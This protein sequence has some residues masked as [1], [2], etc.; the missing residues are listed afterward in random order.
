V[1]P[2]LTPISLCSTFAA[3]ITAG[4][5]TAD[6]AAPFALNPLNAQAYIE[7]RSFLAA[8][9]CRQKK[10]DL[11]LDPDSSRERWEWAGGGGMGGTR[12]VTRAW[13]ARNVC[14]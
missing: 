8:A 5:S 9:S 1:S 13:E 10:S 6:R 12:A 14:F 7:K 2:D 11:F 4:R 3:G